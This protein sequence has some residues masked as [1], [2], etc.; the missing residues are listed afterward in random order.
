M[1][2]L[3]LACSGSEA[4]DTALPIDEATCADVTNWHTVGAPFFYTWCTPC[5]SA[6]LPEEDRQGAPQGMSFETVEDVRLYASII[7]IEMFAGVP[8]MPP[9]GGPSDTELD[10]LADWFDCGLPE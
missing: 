9:S 8:T 5:H 3:L 2:W 7:E 1:L 4:E 6:T 10:A